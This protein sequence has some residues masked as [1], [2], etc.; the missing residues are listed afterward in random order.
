M[1]DHIVYAVPD[2]EAAVKDFHHRAGVRPAMGGKHEGLGTHNAL[3]ALGSAAYLE[4][5]APDPE[6]DQPSVL[7]FGLHGLTRPR[8][9]TWAVKATRLADRVERARVHGYDPG[10]VIP[11]SRVEPDGFRMEW[12]LTF[13]TEL[14]ASGLVPFLIDWSECPN[15]AKS[16]PEGC[17]LREFY[18]R[19]PEPEKVRP[20]LDALGAELDIRKAS[21]TGLVAVLSTRKGIIKL[22]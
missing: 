10:F 15:P 14:T 2:L 20:M 18:G 13:N 12:S 7:P 16:A 8:I 21:V 11:M 5:I 3:V 4:L 6:Q 19:H 9:V 1:L 22:R 17:H